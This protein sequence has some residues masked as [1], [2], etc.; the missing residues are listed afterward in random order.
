MFWP[1]H[2]LVN[3]LAKE[4]SHKRH[5]VTVLTGLP[6][7]P[8]GYLF[9]RYSLL[10]GP[11][12]ESFSGCRVFRVPLLPR[13]KGLFRLA[14]NYASFILFGCLGLVRLR[15]RKFD[16][17]FVFATSPITAAI[18]AIVYKL[19]TRTPV[20]IWVQDLWPESLLAVRALN[21]KHILYKCVGLLVKW[22]YKHCDMILIQ[23]PA[24]EKNVR[25]FLEGKSVPIQYVP[26]WFSP[27]VAAENKANWLKDLPAGFKI[28]FAGNVGLAQSV[29]TILAA[30]KNLCSSS[31]KNA[32]PVQFVIVGDGSGLEQMKHSANEQGISN[33]HF[34]GRKPVED[35]PSLFS[36]CDALLVTLSKN[37]I[38]ALTVP[39]KVQ[40]YLTAGR[41][42]LASLDGEGARVIL[43]GKAGL[44]SPAE[45]VDSLV[46][47]ILALKG[48][49]VNERATMGLNGRRY[50]EANFTKDR[51]I[52]EIESLLFKASSK[53]AD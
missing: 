19:F 30:A 36:A 7:Y 10:S 21:E 33:I 37:E 31:G 40:A 38:F 24:F 3:E 5:D 8:H 23:S 47:N 53:R 2:F 16:V 41:P 9:E 27:E 18:P 15:K 32:D 46:S 44:A 20:V 51:I 1:E 4:L 6:N 17:S 29:E 34:F 39:S 22:I 13:G 49:S 28:C 35:M 26:N 11:W 50:F 52:G 25:K 43:E 48:M 42:I 12:T 14:L 45:D